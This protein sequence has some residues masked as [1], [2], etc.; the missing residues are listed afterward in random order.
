MSLHDFVDAGLLVWSITLT[1]VWIHVRN[2]Q[3]DARL[4]FWRN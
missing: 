1:T 3:L 4:G 2:L